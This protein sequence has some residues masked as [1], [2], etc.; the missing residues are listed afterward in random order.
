MELQ[1]RI[2][3]IGDE[4]RW[5]F[6]DFFE[7]EVMPLHERIGIGKI[8][9]GFLSFRDDETFVWLQGFRDRE[10]RL[11]SRDSA[12]MANAPPMRKEIIRN[13]VPAAGSTITELEGFDGME[14]SPVLEIRQ[15]R[16]RP[17]KRL[18]FAEFF[19]DRALPPHE[20]LGMPIYGQFDSLDDENLFVF[21]RGFPSLLERDQIKAEFYQSRL[22]L[23]EMQDEAFSMIEDYSNVLLVTPI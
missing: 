23:E 15:Y 17:G 9:G 8:L 18:R 20:R 10:E 1:L 2:C 7:R 6:V 14:E 12:L 22:W 3:E 4:R 19:R 16:I 11:A 13:L 21:L 5:N